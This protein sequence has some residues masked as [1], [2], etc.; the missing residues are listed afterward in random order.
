MVKRS[1]RGSSGGGGGPARCAGTNREIELGDHVSAIA[2][3]R[4]TNARTSDSRLAGVIAAAGPEFATQ[5][6]SHWPV[7]S[8]IPDEF[9]ANIGRDMFIEQPTIW[10]V[11]TAMTTSVTAIRTGIRYRR[12]FELPNTSSLRPGANSPLEMQVSCRSRLVV[13]RQP[14]AAPTPRPAVSR[15][16]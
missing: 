16:E 7:K 6:P 15:Q 1:P 11:G 9:I 14:A 5:R 3:T 8:G 12:M 4:P 2:T 10:H 13:S